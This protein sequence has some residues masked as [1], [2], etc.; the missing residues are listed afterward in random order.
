MLEPKTGDHIEGHVGDGARA[1]AIGKQVT[2]INAQT[3]YMQ[4]EEATPAEPTDWAEV[5]ARYRVQ[6]AKHYN[7]LA[8]TGLPERDPN[9][10]EITLENIFVKLNVQLPQPARQHFVEL[11]GAI[12]PTG[13]LR[14]DD[15]LVGPARRQREEIQRARQQLEMQMR[16]PEPVTLSVAE[17]LQ[18]YRCM[19]VLGGPGSGKTTLTRWLAVLFAHENQAKPENLGPSFHDN[20]LP[21]LLELR[22]FADHLA[23]LVQPGIVPDLAAAIAAFISAHAYYPAVPAAFVQQALAAGRCLL[24]FDGLDEIADLG[25]RR[26]LSDAIHALWQHPDGGYRDNLMVVTS[27]PHGYQEVELGGAFQRC[28][29]KE[30]S[31]EDV[32][33]FIRAW[34]ATAYGDAEQSEAQ[35]PVDA[36]QTNERVGDLARNPLLCT[37][38]AIVYRNNRV[39]PNRRVELYFKCCEALL[40]TWE[41]NKAIKD[42]GLIGGYDWQ[43]KLELLAPVAYWLHGVAERL[44]AP[45][46]EFVTQLAAVLRQRKL[47]DPAQAEQEARRF[48]Q[49]VRDRSGLLQGRGDGSLEFMHRTFQEYL[50]ARHIAA[51]PDPD[52]IDLVMKDLHIAWWRE[53]HLLVIGYLGS[54]SATAERASRLLL[55]I[56]TVQP[57]PWPWLRAT[58]LKAIAPLWLRRWLLSPID[59]IWQRIVFGSVFVLTVPYLPWYWVRLFGPGFMPHWSLT[60][61]LAWVL[62]RELSL[63]ARGYLDCTPHGVTRAVGERLHL[64]IERLLL[65]WTLDP[66][67]ERELAPLGFQ[68]GSLLA[69]LGVQRPTVLTA[70]L[71]LLSAPEW[72]VRAAAARAVGE[73]GQ[74]RAEVVEPLLKLLSDA[75]WPVRARAAEALGQVGQGRAE[76]VEPLLEVLSDPCDDPYGLVRNAAAS[77][78]GQGGAE[79]VE[80]LVKLLSDP[81]DDRYGPVREAAARVLGQVGQGGAEVVE[82]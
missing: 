77:A 22:R 67:D 68:A 54:S 60:S 35:E 3:V 5:E 46:A 32:Q 58:S 31:P 41:R 8:L 4:G 36:I 45:E 6:V 48:I 17:A 42:S 49:V 59:T 70:L 23:A 43:T 50:A 69:Q 9:L 2:Q 10:H 24:L 26:T 64:L 66:I 61:R 13:E 71:A 12:S 78:L 75:E 82:P 14:V 20:R 55:A 1:V 39:L 73:V 27:R 52:Y 38:I 33:H 62:Q 7:K 51:Q 80:P 74:G 34:Y 44:A 11:E 40:D 56:L 15:R 30:F 53:V 25:L 81:G 79:V 76:V 63:A 28:E 57:A 72:P 65:C 18:R 19:V 21:V 29:V 37:I 47:G 16:P